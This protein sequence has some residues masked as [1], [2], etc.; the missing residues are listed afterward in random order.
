M[1]RADIEHPHCFLPWQPQQRLLEQ[2]Q[3]YVQP[4]GEGKPG[5]GIN[6][7]SWVPQ[8]FIHEKILEMLRFVKGIADRKP[9]EG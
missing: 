1:Q 8:C 3:E 4:S 7:L 6:M 2:K 5:M 9:T